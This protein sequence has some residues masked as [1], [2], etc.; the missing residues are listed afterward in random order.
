[1]KISRTLTA[2]FAAAIVI[3]GHGSAAAQESPKPA[4]D[5]AIASLNERLGSVETGPAIDTTDAAANAADLAAIEQAMAA[6]GTPAFPVDGFASFE[7]VCE[8]LNR[9][10]VRHLLDGTAALRRPGDQQTPQGEEIAAF[11]AKLQALQVHNAARYEE[12]IVI[13]SGSGIRC[14]AQHFPVLADHLA[15]LP[16]HEIT[17]VRLNGARQMRVGIARAVLGYMTALREPATTPANRA[18][19]HAYIGELA[20]PLAAALT[21]ELRTEVL[22][23]LGQLPPTDDAATLAT[24]ELLKA[25]LA[26][27]ECTQLCIYR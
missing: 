6:F 20:A 9:L 4:F 10:S 7:N 27:T 22:T 14:T 25:A 8:P 15:S 17:T 16:P 11:T 23:M 13:L 19:I 5:N 2:A 12:A 24:T 18:R 1:M 21:P 26:T 3:A